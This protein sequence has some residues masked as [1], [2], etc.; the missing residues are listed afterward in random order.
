MTKKWVG[1]IILLIAVLLVHIYA[2]TMQS[3]S[4][5][6]SIDQLNGVDV[7]RQ[8]VPFDARLV[9]SII[10][11]LSIVG[12]WWRTIVSKMRRISSLFLSLIVVAVFMSACDFRLIPPGK[13]VAVIQPSEALFLVDTQSSTADQAN[14]FTGK[15]AAYWQSNAKINYTEVAI[16]KYWF[17]NGGFLNMNGYWRP[18]SRAFIVSRAISRREWTKDTE[19]GTSANDDA[20]PVETIESIGFKVGIVISAQVESQP[21]DHGVGGASAYLSF[22]GQVPTI[23]QGTAIVRIDNLNDVMDGDVRQY[24]EGRLAKYFGTLKL[25]QAR[26]QKGD[27]VEKVFQEAKDYFHLRG[28]SIFNLGFT[29]GLIYDDTEIQNVINNGFKA[30]EAQKQAAGEA[31]KNLIIANSAAVQTRTA[32]EAAATEQLIM[33][34]AA[35]DTGKLYAQATIAAGEAAAQVQR[36]LGEA[37][38]A[39]PAVIQYLQAQQWNG[40]LPP[41]FGGGSSSTVGVMQLPNLFSSSVPTAT[42]VP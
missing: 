8:T 4:H 15:D 27:V 38:A 7:S 11:G 3:M 39:N 9:V 1:T 25:S 36:D 42:P 2:P 30:E 24:I 17:V 26:E 10:A 12:L 34:Q 21:D 32:A 14:N 35:N 22:Y 33:A 19:T 41:S 5:Q 13:E 18:S 28:V 23:D 31:Q 20:I 6:A 40:N 37:I 16:D 29:D